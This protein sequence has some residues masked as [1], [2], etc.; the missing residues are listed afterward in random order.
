MQREAFRAMSYRDTF[1]APMKSR[2]DRDG[3]GGKEVGGSCDFV[4]VCTTVLAS[5]MSRLRRFVIK[6]I[7]RSKTNIQLLKLQ[8]FITNSPPKSTRIPETHHYPIQK[9]HHS[10]IFTKIQQN[11]QKHSNSLQLSISNFTIH[12]KY[13]NKLTTFTKFNSKFLDS[14]TSHHLHFNSPSPHTTT[15][16]PIF[17]LIFENLLH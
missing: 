11:P 6:T 7:Q 12:Y 17:P 16:P 1:R 14:F 4:E 9:T 3:V 13:L 15:T 8:K 5:V 2:R 10:R